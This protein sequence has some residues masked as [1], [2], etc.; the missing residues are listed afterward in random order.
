MKGDEIEKVFICKKHVPH[1]LINLK[2]LRINEKP[3]P[4]SEDLTLLIF[5]VF[6]KFFNKFFFSKP[7]LEICVY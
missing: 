3:R 5:L 6:S 1:F 2:Y 4:K 7:T